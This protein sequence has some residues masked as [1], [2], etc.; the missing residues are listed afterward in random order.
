M[1]S[2]K[3]SFICAIP[4][5][6]GAVRAQLPSGFSGQQT[7]IA[8]WFRASADG[9]STNGNSWCGYPYANDSPGFAPDISVMTNGTNAVWGTDPSGWA[10][11]A[12][13]YCGL[14]AKVYDPHSGVTMKLFIIDAFDHKWVR[15]PGSID[16]MIDAWKSLTKKGDD[17]LYDSSGVKVVDK[18]VQWT[19]TGEKSDRWAFKGLGSG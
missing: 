5:L 13:Q 8:S 15:T 10:K 2:K 9:D 11:A 6:A 3:V 19:L 17:G 14:E 18:G 4:L 16:V 7:G 12:G 1:F